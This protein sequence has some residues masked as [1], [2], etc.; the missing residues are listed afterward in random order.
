MNGS[1]MTRRG[2]IA[3]FAAGAISA[4]QPA[5]PTVLS[6]DFLT[7][8]FLSGLPIVASYLHKPSSIRFSG[9]GPD[10]QL[11]LNGTALPWPDCA[12]TTDLQPAKSQFRFNLRLKS[13]DV[14]LRFDYTLNGYVL[15][16]ELSVLSDPGKWLR[17]IEWANLPLLT[18]TDPNTT[19]WRQAWTQR[20]WEE[21]IGRGLWR[22]RI[23]ETPLPAAAP[24]AAPQPTCYC[25][26]YTPQKV[27]A[28]VLSNY[29]Y[30]P[31][32]DQV[33]SG[34]RYS[35][36]L[37][38]YQCL[39]RGKRMPP[40]KA[41]IAFLADLNQD[42]R[43]DSSDFQLWVNRQLPKPAD[44]HRRAIWYKVFCARPG[45]PPNTTFAQA[46]EIIERIHRFT[47]GLPQIVYLVGWQYDGHDSG[48]PSLDKLNT[49][50]G[51]REELYGLHRLSKE[52][53]NTALSYH[54]NLD[55]AYREHPG[56][57]PSIITRQ[58]DGGLGRWEEFNGKMSYH[59]SHTKDVESGKIFERLNAMLK[60]VPLEK[61]IH[62]DAF[63]NMNW[64]WEPDGLIGPTDELE[65]GIKPIVEF[66][67]SRGIDL[68]TESI[69]SDAAEWCGIVSGVWHHADPLPMLQL[70]HGKLLAGGRI[71][72]RSMSRWG[73]GTSLNSDFQH[74]ID[75]VD[76]IRRG[77]WD[78]LL[79][80][81]YLGTLLYHFY[82]E[83]EMTVLRFDDKEFRL[84]FAGSVTTVAARD[85]TALK[86]TYGDILVA[87]DYDRFIPRDDAIYCYS[88]DGSKRRWTLPA[89]F[90]GKTLELR[91]LGAES[92]P[93]VVRSAATASIELDLKPRSPV[94][95]TIA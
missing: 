93:A 90:R 66:F 74:T 3:G 41:Q 65:C 10:G 85:N 28:A 60:T 49:A 31:L 84:E 56:W 72:R 4:A 37:N 70:R 35:I 38:T 78:K 18:C 20:G 9:G 88:R 46:R 43:I 45:K 7:V 44:T 22:A 39:T 89:G 23:T 24:D 94:K 53:L 29:A 33:S 48:Y 92:G 82:L 21:K 36:S 52:R 16:Q 34:P 81:I 68:T 79:D 64:S 55:D 67:R 25:C 13:R 54:I 57:D 62:I 58:P 83:R 61:A 91:T 8:E 6:N 42:G 5:S 51:T 19:L 63:R 26:A 27:C 40:L 11:I 59:I 17:T 95:I 76:Y 75:G 71:E 47:D 69:D 86:V 77:D 30:M 2:A 50:L 15:T 73:L 32:R 12:I 14:A 80:D 87:Q 1:R